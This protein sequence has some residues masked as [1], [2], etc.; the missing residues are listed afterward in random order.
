MIETQWASSL[1]NH[2]TAANGVLCAAYGKAMIECK[3]LANKV[4]RRCA[5]YEDGHY[6]PEVHIEFNDG[7]FFTACLQNQVSVAATYSFAQDGEPRVLQ[8]Y[9]CP[10]VP[11]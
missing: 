7:T 5:I 11:R 3:E 9:S 4:V 10:A 8:D 6:G 1:N 2:F